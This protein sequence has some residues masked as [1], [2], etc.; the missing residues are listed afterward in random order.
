MPSLEGKLLEDEKALR[1]AATK[2]KKNYLER[3]VKP[4][5]IFF[6]YFFVFPARHLI[7]DY[8]FS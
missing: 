1:R 6:V 2:R 5:A 3:S 4:L 7:F 8:L